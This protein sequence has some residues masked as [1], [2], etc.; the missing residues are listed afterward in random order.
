MEANLSHQELQGQFGTFPCCL[1]PTDNSLQSFPL[2]LF[3]FI[4]SIQYL[5][6]SIYRELF[7]FFCNNTT[8]HGA[9]RQPHQIDQ[10]KCLKCG[11]CLSTCK[12][13]AITKG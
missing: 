11:A 6:T 4:V 9:I 7:Q 13:G 12:F 1:T 3:L 5:L 2:L 10:Q 8:I